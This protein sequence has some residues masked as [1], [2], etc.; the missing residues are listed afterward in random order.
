MTEFLLIRNKTKQDAIKF[1]NKQY[2]RN[3]QSYS[4]Y[5]NTPLLNS[6]PDTLKIINI[7][8]L[9]ENTKLVLSI[10]LTFLNLQKVSF[11]LN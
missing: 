10:I 8:F 9:K 7:R 11:F 4:R 6:Y 3:N 5:K 2:L 1:Q